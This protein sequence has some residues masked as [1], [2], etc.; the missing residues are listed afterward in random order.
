MWRVHR[1]RTVTCLVRLGLARG[2]R[3]W[4]LNE[5][6]FRSVRATLGTDG[7]GGGAE[8]SSGFIRSNDTTST[9]GSL[10]DTRGARSP[11]LLHHI[12]AVCGVCTTIELPAPLSVH[13]GDCLLHQMQYARARVVHVWAPLRG[14]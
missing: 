13:L 14:H 10:A 9:C 12:K 5:T 4:P 8:W 1:N 2:D 11:R 7:L 6:H 3:E